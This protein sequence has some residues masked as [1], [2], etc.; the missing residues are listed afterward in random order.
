MGMENSWACSALG[1]RDY[2]I[3]FVLARDYW[4]KAYASE[5]GVGQIEYGLE[6]IGCKRLLALVSPGNLL[7]D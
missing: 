1:R 7:P 3:G 2:E 6:V 5:I 4:G